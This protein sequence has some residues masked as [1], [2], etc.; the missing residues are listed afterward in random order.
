MHNEAFAKLGL[1]YCYMCYEVDH[2]NLEKT[3]EG[4]KAMKVRGWN[5]SMPNKTTIVKYLDHLTPV[6]KMGQA[7]NT[8]INDDGV[9]T[10]TTTDG[11]GFIKA[12]KESNL[13]PIGK[14]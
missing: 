11:V 13:D 14:K 9:L 8:V 5:V 10:G 3:V 2:E 4:L 12:L 6:A 7:V 1:D